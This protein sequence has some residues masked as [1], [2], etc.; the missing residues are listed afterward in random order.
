MQ[1]LHDLDPDPPATRL[2]PHEINPHDQIPRPQGLG[3]KGTPLWESFRHSGWAAQRLRTWAVLT[4]LYPDGKRVERFE[5]CGKNAWVYQDKDAPQYFKVSSDTCRDRWCLPCGQ[6]RARTIAAN[7]A[8]RMSKNRFRFV[9]LTLRQCDTPL[10]EMLQKLARC[11]ARLRRVKPWSKAQRGGVAFTEVKH[12]AVMQTWN[13]HLHVLTE[14]GYM[15]KKELSKAWQKITG[16]SFIVDLSLVKSVF[17]VVRYVTKYVSKPLDSTVVTDRNVLYDAIEGLHG[18]RM[19]S[20]FG[21]WRGIDLT[22]RTETR[23]WIPYAPLAVVEK[24]AADP[25]HIDWHVWRLICHEADPADFPRGPPI[26]IPEPVEVKLP[27]ANPQ[28]TFVDFLKRDPSEAFT[29]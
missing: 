27:A 9:T 29:T 2:D 26:P 5:N 11:F 1:C 10:P 20:T 15:L 14:G 28:R 7:V 3:E 18:H 8:E 24:R 16:D 22:A 19:V 6:A 25:E 21:T 4:T 23:T 13:V 12:N 17:D